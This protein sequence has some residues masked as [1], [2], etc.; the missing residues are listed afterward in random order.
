MKIKS[1]MAAVALSFTGAMAMA[2]TV[3]MAVGEWA[4]YVGAELPEQGVH[5]QKVR[6][7]MAAAGYEV[8]LDF[9]PWKR[10]YELTKKGE[11]PATFSWSKT[12][13]RLA[14]FYYPEVFLEDQ[15][16]VIYY[17]RAKYPDGLNVSSIEDI[18]AQGLKLVGY[19]GY[20]YEK[21]LADLGSEMHDVFS[22][23]SAWK[24]LQSGRVDLLIEN[25]VAGDLSL[26]SV[27]GAE[28]GDIAKGSVVRSVPVYVLFSRAHPQ[29]EALKDA[30]DAHAK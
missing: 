10:S 12:D 19:S 7:V 3:K 16:D 25:E 13:D 11:Y 29:G 24:L 30:W 8:A 17:S 15:V 22:E 21:A 28:M 20:W 6:E 18:H 23:E 14:D 26:K 9:L 1:L 2:E 5:A 4:P 27:L